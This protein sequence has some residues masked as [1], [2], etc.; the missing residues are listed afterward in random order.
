[1]TR[2]INS[3]GTCEAILLDFQGARS[4]SPVLDVAFFIYTSTDKE[5]RDKHFQELLQYYYKEL[6]D[7]VTFLGSDMD[8]IYPRELFMKEVIII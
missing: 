2:T 4:A 8:A 5:M 6:F 3:T 7:A 1:M